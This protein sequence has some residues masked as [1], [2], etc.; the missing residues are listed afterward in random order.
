MKKSL[1]ALAAFSAL[2]S[3]SAFAQQAGSWQVGAGWLHF[4]PQDSSEP[5]RFTSPVNRTVA[6][7]GAGVGNADTLGLNATYF[8]DD[9]WAT[10]LELG[11]PPK[12]KL[13]GEG[14]LA[15]LGEIGTAQQWSPT[16]LVK[17]Y[18]NDA[19]AIF[20]P[21]LG[22]GATYVFYRKVELSQSLQGAIAAQLG[23]PSAVART[24]AD[25]DSS[26][27]P[28]FNV[29][30]AYKFDKNWGMVASVS[31]IPLKTKAKLTTSIAGRD[32]ATSQTRLKLNPIVPYIGLTYTF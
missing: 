15:R 13:S 32:V 5:L 2:A 26:F 31:Y 18:F 27:A 4:A 8:V 24:S 25:L 6:G 10:Q 9:H 22:L 21:Y 11:I 29:G 30:A 28:V 7:S 23:A 12:F 1:L 19:N 20:R 16:V 3:G 17:Y 14:T